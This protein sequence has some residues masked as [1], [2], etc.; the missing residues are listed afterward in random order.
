MDQVRAQVLVDQAL[1]HHYVDHLG[2]WAGL[3]SEIYPIYPHE[4]GPQRDP[5]PR[6]LAA[7]QPS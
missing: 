1:V 2:L 5:K 3:G 4:V 7:G 6:C